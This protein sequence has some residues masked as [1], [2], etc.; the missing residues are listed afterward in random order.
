MRIAALLLVLVLAACDTASPP[1]VTD[2]EPRVAFSA[3]SADHSAV[4]LYVSDGASVAT[5]ILSTAELAASGGG[6]SGTFGSVAWS[7]DG[8]ALA[9]EVTGDG[10]SGVGVRDADGSV[11]VVTDLASGTSRPRWS[12]SGDLLLVDR[13][14]PASGPVGTFAVAADGSGALE[15][16][17]CE[18]RPL[19]FGEPVAVTGEIQWGRTDDELVIAIADPFVIVLQPDAHPAHVYRVD[20]ATR[21][22]AQ[23]LTIDPIEGAAFTLAPGG[24]SVAFTRSRE[25][26]RELYVVRPV[27]GVPARVALG[28]DVERYGWGRD[29]RLWHVRGPDL[30]LASLRV[31]APASRAS[32]ALAV[33]YGEVYGADI[34]SAD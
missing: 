3:L 26:T 9:F 33:G 1:P 4:S 10:G 25:D 30:D 7:P 5:E 29:G 27:G 6:L 31:Y 23:R 18:A 24:T 16:V 21:Q 19:Q 15:C 14:Q 2:V 17:V 34:V 13:T 12:P 22:P 11:R 20:R 28:G 32:G 8:R